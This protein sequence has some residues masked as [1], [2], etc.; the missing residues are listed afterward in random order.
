MKKFFLVLGGIFFALLVIMTIA[1]GIAFYKGSALDDESRKYVEAT[2]PPILST[3]SVAKLKESSSP[4]L[5]E[6][7]ENGAETTARLFEKLSTLGQLQKFYDVTGEASMN[8]STEHG[9]SITANYT[10]KADF[11]N[12]PA[13]ITI[14]LIRLNEKWLL[15]RLNVNSEALLN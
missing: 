14:S 3:W 5:L 15:L 13:I 7:L 9:N 4:Q 2:V 1:L 10:A 6:V 12:G 8:A 11:E